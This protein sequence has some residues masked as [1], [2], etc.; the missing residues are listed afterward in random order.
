MKSRIKFKS[1]ALGMKFVVPGNSSLFADDR[2]D[3]I[4]INI[5]RYRDQNRDL[6]EYTVDRAGGRSGEFLR[7]H[8]V[9]S[10]GGGCRNALDGKSRASGSKITNS[11][12]ECLSLKLSLEDTL[13]S[14]P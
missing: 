13:Q 5:P 2:S 14:T 10:C 11:R 7:N 9:I 3:Q 8:T 12:G 6:I 1:K 4:L